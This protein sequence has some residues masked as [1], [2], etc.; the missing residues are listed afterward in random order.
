MRVQWESLIGSLQKDQSKEG[1]KVYF[2]INLSSPT[3]FNQQKHWQNSAERK[4]GLLYAV[5]QKHKFK[6][7][8]LS[9][10]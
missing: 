1:K 8:F 3:V 5:R 10:L 9:N 7:Q 4:N 6:L 2:I